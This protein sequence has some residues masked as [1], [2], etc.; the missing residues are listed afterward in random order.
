MKC[1]TDVNKGADP[2]SSII[3][4]GQLWPTCPKDVQRKSTAGRAALC[5]P[6]AEGSR[7]AA[8]GDRAS[9]AFVRGHVQHDMSR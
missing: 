9:W 5:C 3:R 8:C 6:D 2:H 7:I 4:P 1:K